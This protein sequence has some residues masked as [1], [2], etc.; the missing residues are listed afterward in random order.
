MIT[1]KI[2]PSQL[3][4][5]LPR[6]YYRRDKSPQ[7]F[8]HHPF[9]GSYDKA[10][11]TLTIRRQGSHLQTWH[12]VWIEIIDGTVTMVGSFHQY[13]NLYRASAVEFIIKY[14]DDL[15]C[16]SSKKI[17]KLV[18]YTKDAKRPFKVINGE[19]KLSRLGKFEWTKETD[20]FVKPKIYSDWNDVPHV[21]PIKD[22]FG[23]PIDPGMQVFGE[24]SKGV[25]TFGEVKHIT[26]HEVTKKP[27]LHVEIMTSSRSW[28][29][30]SVLKLY[31]TGYG[32]SN[33]IGIDDPG[34]LTLKYLYMN[35]DP[36]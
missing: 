17:H 22:F 5:E 29:T 9:L 25:T 26:F 2:N 16:D 20:L 21:T 3:E 10:T 7:F 19:G 30:R 23:Q 12:E 13:D 15:Y 28:N 1:A 27:Y 36:K 18:E 33:F 8:Q 32:R 35:M 6:S 4:S 11:K 14:V 31:G 24:L 34:F